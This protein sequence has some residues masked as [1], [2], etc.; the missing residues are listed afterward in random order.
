[1]QIVSA[2]AV[3]ERIFEYLDMKTEQY[4]PPDAIA[5]EQISGDIAFQ[6]ITFGYNDD[7]KILK[8]V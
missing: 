6:N 8:D 3:F 2:F 5:L 4:E 1:V 7:R